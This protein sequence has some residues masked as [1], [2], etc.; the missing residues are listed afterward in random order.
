M[1]NILSLTYS[2]LFL[3]AGL[4]DVSLSID[5]FSFCLYH[6]KNVA[7]NVILVHHE[8]LSTQQV[9]VICTQ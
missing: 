5:L 6:R 3:A 4:H 8:C 7:K 1:F 9:V 2:L